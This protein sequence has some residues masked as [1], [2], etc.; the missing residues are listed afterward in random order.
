M[1]LTNK[2]ITFV[3]VFLNSITNFLL[4]DGNLTAI[5]NLKNFITPLPP[6]TG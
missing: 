1:F 2:N 5:L 3:V 6:E 4:N